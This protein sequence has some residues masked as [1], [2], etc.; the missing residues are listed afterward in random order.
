MRESQMMPGPTEV[1]LRVL[2][3]MIQPTI[4]H[5]DPRFAEVVDETAA[6]LQQIFR[7]TGEVLLLVSSGRGGLEAALA[8]TL[9]PGDRVV[10]LQNGVFGNMMAQIATRLGAEVAGVPSGWGE[11]VDL[12][13]I[14]A[15]LAEKPTKAL[16]AVHGESSTGAANPAAELGELAR[17]HGAVYILDCVSSLGGVDV[18]VD[19]W[20]VDLAIAGSQKCL[21]APP[22]LAILAVN[23]RMWDLF[24]RRRAPVSSFYFDLL[25]WKQMWLPKER[26]GELRFGY[27]RQPV[28]LAIHLV[29]ALREAAQM[30]LEEGLETC[31]ARHRRIQAALRAAVLALGLEMLPPPDIQLPTISAIRAPAGINEAE[32]RRLM[33][34]RYGI[35]IDGGLEQL[36]GQIFRIGHLG[37]TASPEFLMPT[38]TALELALLEL[39]ADVE[40]GAGVAA[41]WEML[42][43]E[44]G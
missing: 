37:R 15:A 7:T 41:A 19:D 21:A 26:G 2:R 6:R 8:S 3:A 14:A 30:L 25:R 29:Y 44:R 43:E 10:I 40:V 31:H 17:A 16:A 18:R 9:E 32:L 33:R 1:D 27:R 38:I 24:E 36:R 22:G 39:G 11:P 20:G 4:N 5:H 42:A 35:V 12:E 28:T 23:P 13:R 34:E